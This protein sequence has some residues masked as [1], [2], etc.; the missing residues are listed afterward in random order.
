MTSG[1]WGRRGTSAADSA[2]RR[3]WRL[4]FDVAPAWHNRLMSGGVWK[5]TQ[6][7]PVQAAKLLRFDSAAQAVLF[8]ERNGWPYELS[9]AS[10]PRVPMA[11]RGAEST[12]NQYQYNIFPLAVQAA[13]AATGA[14][15]RAK[16]VFA[17]DASPVQTGDST[18][19]NLRTTGFGPDVWRPRKGTAQTEKAWTGDGW[20]A[21]V[22]NPPPGEEGKGH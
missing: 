1:P 21:A 3:A 20:A 14:P 8:C 7:T 10:A 11:H 13:M 9:N 19:V 5:S 22:E 4:R 17:Y 12:G 2:S 6:D 15:R 16:N 18:W